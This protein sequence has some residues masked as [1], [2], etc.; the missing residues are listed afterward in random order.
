[1]EYTLIAAENFQPKSWSGGTTTELFIFSPGAS[2]LQRN[3]QFRLSTATVETDQSDF[4]VL[5]NVSRT[6]MVLSGEMTLHHEGQHSRHLSKF[7]VDEFRGDWKTSSLGKCTDFNLM[8][9][10]KTSGTLTAIVVKANQHINHTINV[11]GHWLFMY[12]YNGMVRINLHDK[13]TIANKGDL[14]VIHKLITGLDIEGL[15][16]SELILSEVI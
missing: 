2:Y 1:M 14:L 3:F 8:T 15:E 6:L 10:G 7:D 11:K 9:V 16:N 13:V 12:V 4:S 5:P